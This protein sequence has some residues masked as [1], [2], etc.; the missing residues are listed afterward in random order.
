MSAGLNL[1]LLF[2]TPDSDLWVNLDS[3]LSSR[4]VGTAGKE[5][6]HH[7]SRPARGVLFPVTR[8]ERSVGIGDWDRWCA[9]IGAV[10]DGRFQ[11]KCFDDFDGF[12][13]TSRVTQRLLGHKIH[14]GPMF[15]NRTVTF[16]CDF[17]RMRS[18][19][20]SFNSGGLGVESCSRPVVCMFATVRNRSQPSASACNRWQ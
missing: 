7:A 3:R 1:A 11:R 2:L 13:G 19:G 17:S 16:Q 12:N 20:F 18:E 4:A 5:E 10:A 6:T 15:P 14:L 9:R 8:S